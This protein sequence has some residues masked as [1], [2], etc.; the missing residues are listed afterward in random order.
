MEIETTKPLSLATQSNLIKL[1]NEM[2]RAILEKI[3]RQWFF[4]VKRRRTKSFFRVSGMRRSGNHAVIYWILGQLNGATCFNNNMGPFHP[5]ENTLIKRWFVKGI[6]QFNLLVSLEDKPCED[7]FLPY[8]KLKFGEASQKY[9]LLIL[10]D[11]YN[12]F[13]SRWAWKDEFG[14]LFRENE[15]HQQIIIEHWKNHARWYLQN[16]DSQGSVGEEINIR[17][18][19][20]LWFQDLSY[21]KELAAKLNLK[22]T[23]KGKEKISNYGFGSSFNGTDLNNN[24]SQLKVLNRWEALKNDSS[25]RA[26]FKDKELI[27]LARII[28]KM[29]AAEKALMEVD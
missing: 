8:D 18:N 21:R 14:R 20:N 1:W 5:P 26:L 12:M 9:N 10:R 3:R 25:Y 6:S 16:P 15:E 23:D 4:V 7:A 22:F 19:Y 29:S 2:Q 11:P 27:E 13:A 24:A 17:V 28:F